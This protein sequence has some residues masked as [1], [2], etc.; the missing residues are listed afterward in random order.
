M[1]YRYNGGLLEFH[2]SLQEIGDINDHWFDIDPTED[3]D[4]PTTFKVRNNFIC[5][6]S[7]SSLIKYH[8]SQ[9]HNILD[10]ALSVIGNLLFI[11]KHLSFYYLGCN[12]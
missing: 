3:E 6:L 1:P 4:L 7:E 10:E 9:L 5:N 2:K 11:E 8:L 12:V